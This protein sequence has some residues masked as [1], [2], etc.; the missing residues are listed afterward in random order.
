MNFTQHFN[1]SE[2]KLYWAESNLKRKGFRA[3]ITKEAGWLNPKDLYRRITLKGNYL[4]HRVIYEL[5]YGDIPNK[6]TVDHINGDRTDNRVENLQLLTRKQNSQRK[7]LKVAKGYTMKDRPFP[8]QA[9]K[10]HNKKRYNLGYFGTPCGA[11]MAHNTFF[12][13]RN[14]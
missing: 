12:I 11:T 3:D 5:F 1:Y 8:Y 13:K 2:G 7:Q 4:A 14:K 9:Q 10:T 6:M